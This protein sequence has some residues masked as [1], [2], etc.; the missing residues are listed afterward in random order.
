MPVTWVADFSNPRDQ[1]MLAGVVLQVAAFC[2]LIWNMTLVLP[3]WKKSK[4]HFWHASL[5]GST[6]LMCVPLFECAFVFSRFTDQTLWSF[7]PV[8]TAVGDFFGRSAYLIINVCRLYRLRIVAPLRRTAATRYFYTASSIIG[9][10]MAACIISSFQ[11]RLAE[12]A[13]PAR[14]RATPE[15]LRL[16][17]QDR[18]ISFIAFM[19]T[20]I[21]S[22]AVDY[23]FFKIVVM[24]QQKI[25]GQVEVPA[26]V[27]REILMPY[28]PAFIVDAVY[29]VCLML[30]FFAPT[31]PSIVFLTITLGKLVPTIDTII[32]FR[33]SI[34]QTKTLLRSL[35][36]NSGGTGT[37]TAG[38]ATTGGAYAM[39]KIQSQVARPTGTMP[40]APPPQAPAP[41]SIH[42]LSLSM[43]PGP[44]SH[45][46]SSNMNKRKSE[47]NTE[48]RGS[49]SYE[50]LP[51][52]N[53]TAHLTIQPPPMP[54]GTAAH[55]QSGLRT[56][57]SPAN[58]LSPLSPP[59]SSDM[60]GH[61]SPRRGSLP[62]HTS[63]PRSPRS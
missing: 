30:S 39:S 8:L 26:D 6:L 23:L 25:H 12:N 16:R 42:P 38:G 55:N 3:H 1:I 54:T 34:E 11:L 7:P 43:K 53:L 4:T 13:L 46:S 50:S 27:K 37:G 45:N 2:A 52:H 19:I 60:N 44:E 36:S 51:R 9:L 17:D 63:D 61:V 14:S 59:F 62:K 15:V 20:T 40:T 10:S 48:D 28:I 32:F 35:T 21:T 18:L 29:I 47:F 57:R 33:F 24:S 5:V 56:P 58:L 22:V 31:I 41:A 49:I